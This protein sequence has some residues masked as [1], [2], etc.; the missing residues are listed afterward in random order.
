MDNKI[1]KPFIRSTMTYVDVISLKIPPYTV[2]TTVLVMMCDD[3][4][5]E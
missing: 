4:V 1:I 5:P 3:P 2:L